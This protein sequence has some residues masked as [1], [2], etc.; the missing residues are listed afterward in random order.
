[1][2]LF[3]ALQLV[4]LASILASILALIDVSMLIAYAFEAAAIA[5]ACLSKYVLA[6]AIALACISVA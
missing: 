6:A 1:M 4:C 3:V 5:L 2:F